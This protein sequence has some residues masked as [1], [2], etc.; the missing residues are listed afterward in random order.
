MVEA[1]TMLALVNVIASDSL[2]REK[3]L[4]PKQQKMLIRRYFNGMT[5]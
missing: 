2:I 3:P 1:N 5:I 4:N